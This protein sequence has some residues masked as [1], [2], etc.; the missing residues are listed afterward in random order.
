MGSRSGA[1]AGRIGS[2][3]RG[4]AS[5]GPLPKGALSARATRPLVPAGSQALLRRR[6]DR[7][8]IGLHAAPG[9]TCRPPRAALPAERQ[10]RVTFPCMASRVIVLFW[11]SW[12]RRFILS[13][14]LVSH[15]KIS[16]RLLNLWI[17]THSLIKTAL[18][19]TSYR[20]AYFL[21]FKCYF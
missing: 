11:N 8:W 17:M 14:T 9:V 16:S 18:V 13:R 21:A 10:L 15:L 6:A 12:L 2:A 3:G 7:P 5:S 4:R 20:D 1:A 19:K